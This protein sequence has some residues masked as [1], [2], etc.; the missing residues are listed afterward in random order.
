MIG[1]R[2]RYSRWRRRIDLDHIRGGMNDLVVWA[3]ESR[4][5]TPRRAVVL[6]LQLLLRQAVE[7]DAVAVNVFY[8]EEDKCLRALEYVKHENE[9]ERWD[10]R[11][12]APA[13]GYFAAQVL[14]ELQ[15]RTGFSRAKSHGGLCYEYAGRCNVADTRWASAGEARIYFTVERPPMR[16]KLGTS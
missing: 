14:K 8:D 2:S 4:R 5:K 9:T 11:E 10:W 7:D 16:S 6:F 12:F 3:P 1:L 15:W 13:P